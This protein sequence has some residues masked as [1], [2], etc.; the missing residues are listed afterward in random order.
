MCSFIQKKQLKSL[1]GIMAKRVAMSVENWNELDALAK[2]PVKLYLAE[3]V[4]FTVVNEKTTHKLWKKL[5]TTYEKETTSN[6][7]YLMK[8]LLEL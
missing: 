1:K 8:W 7:V 4:Y 3:S 2:S 6:K 5:C